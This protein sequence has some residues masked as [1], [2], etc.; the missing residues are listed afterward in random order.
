MRIE[1]TQAGGIG[2]F[3]GLQK[4]VLIDIDHLRKE[5][6][7]ELQR[8]VEAARFFEHSATVGTLAQGAADSQHDIVTVEDGKR[9]H[10]VRVLVP[11]TDP[12]LHD[13][14]RE[15]QKHVKAARAA[16]RDIP[17]HPTSGNVPQPPLSEETQP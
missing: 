13:L 12:A 2:Y 4:P 10:T 15:V 3:P 7:E 1:F 14:L 8:L 5:E 16:G 17:A 6:A 9:R 11:V